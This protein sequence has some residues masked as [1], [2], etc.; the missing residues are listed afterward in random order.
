MTPT[1]PSPISDQAAGEHIDIV[2]DQVAVD[3]APPEYSF[4]E[5]ENSQRASIKFG[6]W[7]HRDDG[8]W[9]LRI[10]TAPTT[11]SAPTVL[12]CA[13]GNIAEP[14]DSH[15]DALRCKSCWSEFA[16]PPANA[17]VASVLSDAELS[18]ID[19]AAC[20]WADDWSERQ[21]LTPSK[22]ACNAMFI[23]RVIALLAASMVENRK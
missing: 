5:V 19:T 2:F 23:R 7:V 16:A 3:G 9:V 10:S 15:V 14:R 8:Y 12:R 11:G 18:E 22:D 1:T 4:I 13:C 20:E 21:E 6:E 17:P